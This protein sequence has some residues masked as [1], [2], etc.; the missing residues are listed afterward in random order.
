VLCWPGGEATRKGAQVARA[1]AVGIGFPAL[2]SLRCF[3][4]RTNSR[5]S[6]GPTVHRDSLVFPTPHPVQAGGA[7]RDLA[8][9]GERW[10]LDW[11]NSVAERM[12]LKY[13]RARAVG[14][15]S[16]L[17]GSDASTGMNPKIRIP[18]PEDRR[19][20]RAPPGYIIRRWKV[21]LAGYAPLRR[22]AR[23]ARIIDEAVP[24]LKPR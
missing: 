8:G 14:R 4:G 23:S 15:K 12:N 10:S 17:E 20:K 18:S 16:R 3:G 19:P 6:T 13:Q 11:S 5:F 22:C 2:P 21:R 9:L 1:E 7:A 24:T